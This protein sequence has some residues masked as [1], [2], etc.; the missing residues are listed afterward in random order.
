MQM[1]GDGFPLRQRQGAEV[2]R[3]ASDPRLRLPLGLVRESAVAE[4]YRRD[5]KVLVLNDCHIGTQL[6][7]ELDRMRTG[8][9]VGA[10]PV[11]VPLSSSGLGATIDESSTG[12]ETK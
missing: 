5:V 8:R 3:A 6:R 10:S 12:R 11:S 1:L 4:C 2:D 7:L 9:K